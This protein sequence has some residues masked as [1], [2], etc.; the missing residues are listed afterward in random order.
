PFSEVALTGAQRFPVPSEGVLTALAS[1]D[2]NTR[3]LTLNSAR[4][5]SPDF[6]GRVEGT[7]SLAGDLPELDLKVEVQQLPVNDVLDFVVTEWLARYGSLEIDA[8]EPSKFFLT[9]N[10]P[11]DSAHL[12]VEA[13]LGNGAIR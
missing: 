8:P 7:V 6:E 11:M 5:I 3:A 1:Y 4:S 12:G 13:Q 10:G 9:L 2:L